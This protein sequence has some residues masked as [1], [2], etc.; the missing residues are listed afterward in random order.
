MA[1]VEA[2]SIPIGVTG[3]DT[4]DKAA[5]SYEDLGDAVA[6]TQLEA[7]KLANTF[8]INDKRTQ[9]AIKVAGR[10]KQEM[11]QLDTAI[12]GARGGVATLTSATQGVVAGFEIAAGVAGI[13]GDE[14]E[15]LQKLLLKVQSAMALSQGLNDFKQ[16][17]PAILSTATAI[18]TQLVAAFTTLRGAI[19]ATGIGALVVALAVAI[20]QIGKYN[21]ALDETIDKEL[22]LAKTRSKE[23]VESIEAETRAYQSATEIRLLIAKKQGK[24]AEEIAALEILSAKERR[25]ALRLAYADESL[26]QEERVKSLEE[27][28]KIDANITKLELNRDITAN[29]TKKAIAKKAKE[30]AK[31]AADDEFNAFIAQEVANEEYREQKRQAEQKRIDEEFDM[32][33]AQIVENDRRRQQLDDE[34]FEMELAQ[35][36]ENDR[37]RTE[38]TAKREAD[39]LKIQEDT[40]KAAQ[41]LL[42]LSNSFIENSNQKLSDLHATRIAELKEQG[43]TEEQIAQ[44]RDNELI[45]IDERAKKNFEIAKRIRYAETLL[46]TIQGTQQAF[47]TANASPIT[48]LFPA[49]PFIQAA[50]AAAFGIA[51]LQ[52]IAQSSY[53]SKNKPSFANNVSGAAAVPRF[54]APS[55]RLNGGDEFTQVRRIYVTERDITNVQDKVRVTEGLSQF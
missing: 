19:M 18:R 12:D 6:K 53:T 20:D 32:E 14:S 5:N 7:E 33:M 51:Q 4:V 21:D 50:T 17:L 41:E 36:V 22:E 49:Y 45:K 38:Q 26:T 29:E 37:R 25:D 52:Q 9:E 1:I 40:F 39:R 24:S 43:F 42:S 48:A 11:E 30:D 46:S 34:A 55:T 8:G 3:Q 16:F 15:E 31:K 10:Y 27:Y 13:F 35:E 54:N 47:T 28:N 2:I 23:G 44:M